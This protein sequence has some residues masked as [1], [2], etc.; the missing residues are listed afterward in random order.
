MKKFLI[1]L[2]IVL[3][4]PWTVIGV[5]RIDAG[6]EGILV[7]LFGSDRGVRDVKLVTGWVFYNR[8][9]QKIYEY[10]TYVQTVD[11]EPFSINAKDGSEFT[12]DPNV[13]LKIEDGKAPQVFRKYRKELKDVI[14]GPIYKHIKDACRI[15]INKFTTDEIVSNRES[16]ENAI[17]KRFISLISKEGFELDQFTSG[18]AYP[19]S[20]VEAVNAKN[21]AI[22]L[23]QKAE[24]EVKVAE[25][26]AKK[27]VV[28]AEAEAEAN[29]LRTQALTPQVLEKMWIDK[30]DG[31]LPV[32]GEV[33]RLFKDISK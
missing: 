8:W 29:R 1:A 17:E 11:Y 16:V 28:A 27:L 7:N 18:L 4:A 3:V 32:Y 12:I 5:E 31:K 24:N 10:A 26:E 19:K 21:R 9:T 25:A 14:A 23:A 30:W 33:P 13:N 2:L 6:C 20:I 22:Q 15:E